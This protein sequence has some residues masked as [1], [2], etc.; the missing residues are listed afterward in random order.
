MSLLFLLLR[1]TPAEWTGNESAWVAGGSVVSDSELAQ[2]LQVSLS[3]V[4]SWRRSLR[5]LKLLGWLLSP[6]NG[7]ESKCHLIRLRVDY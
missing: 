2:G 1:H 7:R 5:K 3:V 6:G 4:K